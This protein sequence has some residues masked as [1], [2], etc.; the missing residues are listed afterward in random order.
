MLS[1][2]KHNLPEKCLD[3]Y[4]SDEQ[5]QVLKEAGCPT[6]A[7]DAKH[8]LTAFLL[9]FFLGPRYVALNG[10]F[11]IY[12]GS[13]G[14]GYWYYGHDLGGGL[15]L[16]AFL[17]VCC[18]SCALQAVRMKDASAEPGSGAVVLACFSCLCSCGFE[19]LLH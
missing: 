15:M 16:G 13:F 17:L 8:Q 9:Q 19:V 18:G 14:S 10:I 5:K 2:L 4:T 6:V 11:I 12:P 1:G 3:K 7:S